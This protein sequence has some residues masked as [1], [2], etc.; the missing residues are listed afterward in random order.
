M[1]LQFWFWI[2]MFLWLFF[3]LYADY[4]AGQ[5]YPVRRGAWSI[6]LFILLAILGWHVFGSPIKP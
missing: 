6:L 5:P 1:T 4:T 3:G 2:I